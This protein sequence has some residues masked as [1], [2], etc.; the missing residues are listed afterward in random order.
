MRS[1]ADVEADKNGKETIIVTEI[2][3]SKQSSFDRENC[4]TS[5]RIRK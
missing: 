4:W 3:P 5:L 2:I 1:K